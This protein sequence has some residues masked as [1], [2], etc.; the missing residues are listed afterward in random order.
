MGKLA[1]IF[2]KKLI[3]LLNKAF[4][5]F[6]LAFSSESLPFSSANFWFFASRVTVYVFCFSRHFMA[7]TLFCILLQKH[8]NN[9]RVQNTTTPT[10]AN[11]KI[12]LLSGLLEFT[13]FFIRKI[14]IGKLDPCSRLALISVR[15]HIAIQVS[16]GSMWIGTRGRVTETGSRAIGQRSGFR[17]S[18][19]TQ[20]TI[21][22]TLFGYRIHSDENSFRDNSS[23]GRQ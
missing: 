1:I 10:T 5:A 20:G 18:G 22:S 4:S 9:V 6:R 23:E 15:R 13:K 7:E 3:C 11:I 19:F 16:I 14:Q 17:A 2:S 12:A 8:R 21:S